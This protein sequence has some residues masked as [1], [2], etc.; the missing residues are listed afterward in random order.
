[1]L[2]GGRRGS[3]GVVLFRWASLTIQALPG[4]GISLS[5][6]QR[7]GRRGSS[8]SSIR[9]EGGH[10][11]HYCMGSS[12]RCC[13]RNALRI[14]RSSTAPSASFGPSSSLIS[15]LVDERWRRRRRR[16]H[17]AA[18]QG[19]ARGWVACE[20][21]SSRSSR[22][23]RLRN[24]AENETPER[25]GDRWTSASPRG[26]QHASPRLGFPLRRRCFRRRLRRL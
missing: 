7:Q 19:G 15:P 16:Y 26:G 6:R 23:E 21:R 14:E 24:A 2:H 13:P 4:V 5:R 17:C 10:R 3:F 22:R 1:M 9:S 12:N 11:W 20:V 18:V 25:R 8:H